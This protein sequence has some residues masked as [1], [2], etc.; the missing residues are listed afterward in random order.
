MSVDV[1]ALTKS[2]WALIPFAERS[3]I[4][5]TEA[6]PGH[7]RLEMPL[8]PNVNHI[9]TMYAGALFTLA[10]IPGGT[11][12]AMSFDTSRFF[13]IVK[14]LRITFLAPASTDISVSV[15]LS[16]SEIDD[17]GARAERDGKADYSWTS[18]LVDADG[19]VVARSENLYQLRSTSRPKGT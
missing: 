8:E 17:I 7:V 12:F 9:G 11:M 2:T 5:I 18:E 1:D 16:E 4:R 10:E 19:T 13:P 3:G 6:R 14:D 15:D